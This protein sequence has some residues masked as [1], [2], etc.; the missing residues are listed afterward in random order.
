MII[1]KDALESRIEGYPISHY[2]ESSM[3][4]D[5]C[6]FRGKYLLTEERFWEFLQ[7][8]FVLTSEQLYVLSRL[9]RDRELN[10]QWIQS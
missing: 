7:D 3:I 4:N 8:E 9:Y 10:P 1:G 5:K 2:V 6:C